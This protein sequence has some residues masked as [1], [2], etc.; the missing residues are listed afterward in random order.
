MLFPITHHIWLF[1]LLSAVP[2]VV[3]LVIGRAINRGIDTSSRPEWCNRLYIADLPVFV[4]LFG[5]LVALALSSLIEQKYNLKLAELTRIY[6]PWFVV[7]W[8]LSFSFLSLF[9][10]AMFF[11]VYRVKDLTSS[12][13]TNTR[14]QL[15]RQLIHTAKISLLA[16]S[17]LTTIVAVIGEVL[18]N[19]L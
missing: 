13:F 10:V 9:T 7:F 2:S 6:V 14:S 5:S 12:E 1:V 15:T 16:S 17:L 8:S 4:G 3:C 19:Y 11:D 18:R